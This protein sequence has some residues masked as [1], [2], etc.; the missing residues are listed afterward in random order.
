MRILTAN[1]REG[2]ADAAAL[3]ALL[4]ERDIDV[5]CFQ[6]LGPA[7]AEAIRD[8][9]PHGLLEPGEGA[10]RF[11]GGGIAARSPLDVRRLPLPGR[12][13][14]R[15]ELHPEA[16]PGLDV[17]GGVELLS[18]HVLVPF[19][20]RSWPPWRIPAIRRRQVRALLDHLDAAPGCSRLLVGDLNS[21]P[22][23]AAYREFTSRLRDLH[24]DDARASGR[25]P[26]PT[27]GP[28]PR[29]PRLWRL[30]HAL[31]HGLDGARVEVVRLQGSDHAGLVV[32]V[33]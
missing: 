2:L 16:W 20:R 30:D 18:A 14:F 6:E 26:P 28:S 33:G 1:L 17:L 24:L 10:R 31:A 5:A 29:G 32:E 19:S 27:W 3:R 9:L 8:A 7:Q 4:V 12:D 23:M 22:S 21:T 13:A 25:R 15:A 11:L